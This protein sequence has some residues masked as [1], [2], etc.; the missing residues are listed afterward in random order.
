[1][2][3]RHQKT[4]DYLFEPTYHEH[5]RSYLREVFTQ[6][7]VGTEKNQSDFH[8]LKTLTF[9]GVQGQNVSEEDFLTIQT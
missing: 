7:E 5:H 6:T 2:E 4:G 8:P 3:D 9:Y 1:M